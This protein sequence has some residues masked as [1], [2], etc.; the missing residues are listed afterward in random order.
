[1]LGETFGRRWCSPRTAATLG[2]MV[3][4]LVGQKALAQFTC[5]TAT[6][7]PVGVVFEGSSATSPGDGVTGLCAPTSRAVWHTFV[8]SVSGVHTVSLCGSGINSVA[9]LYA[10]CAFAPIVC[11]DDTCGDD[12][13][14]VADL[15]AGQTYRLRVA[16]SGAGAGGAYAVLISQP[17]G[18]PVPG[19][20]C[21]IGA[22]IPVNS[23]QILSNGPTVGTDVSA[24][25]TG[26]TSDV[27]VAFSADAPGTYRVQ[28]CTRAFQPVLSV[29]STCF[30]TT[31]VQC[32]V[33]TQAEPCP[34]GGS[35]SL[36]ITPASVPAQVLLRVAGVRGS[37]GP[38]ALTLFAPSGNDGCG[39]ARVLNAGVPALGRTSPII[40]T[41]TTVNCAPSSL[42]VWY[43]FTPVTSGSYTI[44]TCSSATFDTVLSVHTACPGSPG[45]GVIACSDDACGTGSSVTLTLAAGTPYRI[46]VAGKGA[47]PNGQWG[48][49]TILAARNAP[50]NDQCLSAIT[51]L[52]G[53]IFDSSTVG[54]TGTDL[55]PGCADGDT[56]DV[57]FAFT[58][59]VTGVYAVN[60]CGDGSSAGVSVFES[61]TAAPIACNESDSSFCGATAGGRVSVAMV[62][63]TRYLIRVA[64]PGG[65]EGM[66]QLAVVRQPTTGDNC[67]DA[68]ELLGFGPTA[69]GFAG[70]TPSGVS[71]CG[72]DAAAS[73]V[74]FR[75]VASDTR[76][77]R[78]QSCGSS[79]PMTLSVFAGNSCPI[80][81]SPIACG[82]SDPS[83]CG[84]SQGS[85]ARVLLVG[86]QGVLIRAAA[87]T[88][89]LGAASISI[90]NDAPVNDRC[91]DALPL[92]IGTPTLG[93]NTDATTDAL[94]PCAADGRDVWY[95]LVPA[96]TGWYRID[97][98]TTTGNPQLNTVITLHASCASPAYACNDDSAAVCG[99]GTNR[100]G[101]VVRLVAGDPVLL[102]VAGAGGAQ[103]VFSVQWNLVPPPNDACDQAIAIGNGTFEFD[104]LSATDGGP[105][106]D[107]CTLSPPLA[108]LR[109]DVWFR[110][111][112]PQSGMTTVSL[113]GSTFDT[114]LVVANATPGCSAGTL[115]TRQCNDDAVCVPGSGVMTAQSNL[116]FEAV[117]GQTSFVRIGSRNGQGGPGFLRVTQGN[118][119]A[120]DFDG[121]GSISAADV[122]EYLNAWFAQ[123]SSA[124][125]NQSGGVTPADIFDFL[126][127]F[128]TRPPGC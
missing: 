98:C 1:M 39:S 13:V 79:T 42:D 107:G 35:A 53:L 119:C 19:D 109:S 7:I 92:A 125:F 30:S 95:Q 24:C 105:A 26:D 25:G 28:V 11:D 73:D 18:G 61:C 17:P 57:W 33:S 16:T 50:S 15:L 70:A 93:S 96:A 103:G 48:D 58:P 112:A 3:L 83:T 68:I 47:A 41:D 104:T 67:A 106:I 111:T 81:A 66:F 69:F 77:Y 32:D 122:F 87:T 12:A 51:I 22:F 128:F 38:F 126:N 5:Q 127:C 115:V 45:A 49:F 20:L 90:E 2:A 59:S 62:G 118:L 63:G 123:L 89:L 43:V 108:Q 23:T 37:F 4:A 84:T 75:F 64:V 124:D 100:S 55:T 99:V 52:E 102:R 76:F 88:P 117:A 34:E 85:I 72:S 91:A 21:G 78:V 46:R 120:C 65:G 121:N 113:C 86:G 36:S 54:A 44:S 6:P 116:S 101:L 110:Y 97:T 10:D 82:G 8:P 74:W 94:G 114:V 29:Q 14:L 9:T 27:F 40:G 31:S 80:N 60:T 71:S 56:K